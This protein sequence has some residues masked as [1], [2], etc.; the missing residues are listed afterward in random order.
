MLQ[1]LGVIGQLKDHSAIKRFSNQQHITILH[2]RPLN[3][4]LHLQME[5]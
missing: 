1:A 3:N 5:S 2:S 4:N